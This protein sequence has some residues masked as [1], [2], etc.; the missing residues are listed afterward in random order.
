MSLINDVLQ[1]LDARVPVQPERIRVESFVNSKS[2]THFIFSPSVK[3]A[4]LASFGFMCGYGALSIYHAGFSKHIISVPEFQ[5]EVVQLPL[6]TA[7]SIDNTDE[8]NNTRAELSLTGSLAPVDLLLPLP[9]PP[10]PSPSEESQI[11]DLAKQYFLADRLT[12]P[13]LKNAYQLYREVLLKAPN[14][15]AALD[16]IAAIKQRYVALTVEAIAQADSEKVRRYIERAEFVGVD[17]KDLDS[18]RV[19]LQQ[20]L[21]NASQQVDQYAQTQQNSM[22]NETGLLSESKN[23]TQ[24]AA[25]E[26]D[27]QQDDFST[28]EIPMKAELNTLFVKSSPQGS[29]RNAVQQNNYNLASVSNSSVSKKTE[30]LFLADLN[31]D[32]ISELSALSFIEAHTDSTDTVRWLANRWVSAQAWP[33]LISLI[34]R[35]SGLTNTERDVFRAQGLLGLKQYEEIISWLNTAKQLEAAELQRILAVALQKTGREA[36]ALIIYQRLVDHHPQNA[37]LWL[38]LGVCADA[39]G[40]TSL[41]HM[42]FFRAQQLGGHTQAVNDFLNRKLNM[43]MQ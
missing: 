18:M 34:E 12:Y 2:A 20:L 36:Q 26:I 13:P 39:S 43:P 41:A 17:S 24:T 9:L 28:T 32:S 11:L 30:Q 40:N 27:H 33:K 31:E 8:S 7:P 14:N 10:S 25:R 37:G 35:P 3:I 15:Q 5:V 4:V 19:Q 23:I 38:A 1:Q 16:G 42:A 22:P 29:L 21:V 6:N